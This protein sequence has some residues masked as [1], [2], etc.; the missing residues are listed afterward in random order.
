MF[1]DPSSKDLQE[2]P[3]LKTLN[4]SIKKIFF[5]LSS[6]NAGEDT[7]VNRFIEEGGLFEPEA[8]ACFEYLTACYETTF[9]SSI[10]FIEFLEA[11]YS[12]S[13]GVN[14]DF[15]LFSIHY[16]YFTKKTGRPY[17]RVTNA[18]EKVRT[19]VTY[20]SNILSEEKHKSSFAANLVHSTDAYVKNYVLDQFKKKGF[21]I[22]TIHDCFKVH[23]NHASFARKCYN[24]A[25]LKVVDTFKKDRKEFG[26]QKRKPRGFDKK[27]LNS[28]HSITPF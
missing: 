7:I 12:T 25:I 22:L 14:V 16:K 28:W 24:E 19:S 3:E 1:A 4:R 8:K 6:F 5:M 2:K 20:A 17:I 18:D 21:N 26:I 11:K 23:P 15:P 9:D 13:N 10:K 27:V